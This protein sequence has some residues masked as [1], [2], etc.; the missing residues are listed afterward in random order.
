MP[1]ME[2]EI[3]CLDSG[4]HYDEILRLYLTHFDTDVQLP[5]FFRYTLTR[6]AA[7]HQ[8]IPT[9]TALPKCTLRKRWFLAKSIVRLVPTLPEPV[10]TLRALYGSCRSE[11]PGNDEACQMSSAFMASFGDCGAPDDAVRV[12]KDSGKVRYM[13]QLETLAGVLAAAG[14]VAKAMALLRTIEAGGIQ[15]TL[16]DGRVR[17][18][19]APGVYG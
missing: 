14:R 7:Q 13:K 5:G 11:L 16:Q 1:W 12:L 3:R 4:R 2:G 6:I 15:V 19:R 10:A 17:C 9:P 8:L 18:A